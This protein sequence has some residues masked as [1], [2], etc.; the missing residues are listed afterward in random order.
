[1]YKYLWSQSKTIYTDLKIWNKL[2]SNYSEN[3]YSEFVQYSIMKLTDER[4]ESKSI[5]PY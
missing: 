1:M 4:D 3:E 5:N 2:P